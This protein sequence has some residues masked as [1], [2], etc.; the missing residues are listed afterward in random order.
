MLTGKPN[1]HGSIF[2]FEGQATVFYPRQGSLLPLPLSRAAAGRGWRRAAPEAGV[3][4]VLPGLIGACEA[5]EDDQADSRQQ[6][7][8]DRHALLLLQ[9]A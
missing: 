2:Q 4:G 7:S 6:A 1:V 9:H 3:L 8:P 5:L